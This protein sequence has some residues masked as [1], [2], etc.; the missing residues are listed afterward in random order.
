MLG[1]RASGAADA[2]GLSLGRVAQQAH[3]RGCQC[4]R[5]AGGHEDSG[6]GADE[7]THS[8]DIGSDHW[9]TGG[10]GLDE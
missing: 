4:A 5:V 3:E 6:L 1:V 2:E 8:A 10:H 7:I 9:A